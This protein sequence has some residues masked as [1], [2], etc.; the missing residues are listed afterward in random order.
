MLRPK[1]DLP[2]LKAALPKYATSGLGPVTIQWWTAFTEM[3]EAAM[4]T[5][6]ENSPT[7]LLTE[8][9]ELKKNAQPSSV[10]DAL[11]PEQLSHMWGIETNTIPEVCSLTP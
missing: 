6:E 2:S 3:L 8:L 10:E 4:K 7:R 1:V 9:L 11:V 5:H